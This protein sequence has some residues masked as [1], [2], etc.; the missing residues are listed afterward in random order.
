MSKYRIHVTFTCYR[1]ALNRAAL[2]LICLVC[3]MSLPDAFSTWIDMATVTIFASVA[4]VLWVCSSLRHDT[5]YRHHQESFDF[6]LT[7]EGGIYV[8]YDDNGGHRSVNKVIKQHLV[9]YISSD[10]EQNS[11]FQ[12]HC[13]S[14][15][16]PWGICLETARVKT[17]C[18]SRSHTH[19][20]WILKGECSERDYRRLCR[21]VNYV[22]KKA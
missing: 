17:K 20:G 7:D 18:F 16:Y 22:R 3:L 19:F 13:S 11:A 9:T 21:A 8:S 5:R 10:T 14:Q 15:L 1:T 12:I 2:S 4:L 6:T